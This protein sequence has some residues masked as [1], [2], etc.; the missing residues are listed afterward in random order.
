MGLSRLSSSPM[1]PKS[2]WGNRDF[3]SFNSAVPWVILGAFAVFWFS[4]FA[5][6]SPLPGGPDVFVFR[7]AGCNWAGGHG[8]VAASV[9][10]ANTVHSLPF[11]SYTPG[12]LLLFG[13]AAFPLRLLRDR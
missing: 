9:P 7:D 13:A 8:L 4:F 3:W 2:V 6:T 12:A 5:L 1:K 11:A 10:H